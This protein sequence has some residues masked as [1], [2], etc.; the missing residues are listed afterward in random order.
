MSTTEKTQTVADKRAGLVA[1]KDSV[2]A[3]SRP[4]ATIEWKRNATAKVERIEAALAKWP[5]DMELLP[6]HEAI[7]DPSIDAEMR[8]V[9]AWQY[10]A[11]LLYPDGFMW[12]LID[13]AL[14]AGEDDFERLCKEW[15]ELRGIRRWQSEEGWSD[16]IR[17]L[18][19]EVMP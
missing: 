11:Q 14:A 9:L 2:Q 15:P 13:A 6:L 4:F 16:L 7:D 8:L 3:E 5:D 19:I 12:K 10:R 1:W 17:G 18:P